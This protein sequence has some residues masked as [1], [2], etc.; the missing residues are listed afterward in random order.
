MDAYRLAFTDKQAEGKGLANGIS[1]RL[2][3]MNENL[4]P[5]YA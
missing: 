2:F 3:E 1:S 4:D 5:M